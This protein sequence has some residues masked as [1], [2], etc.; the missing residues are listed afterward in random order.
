M[1]AAAALSPTM[2]P[3]SP[4]AFMLSAGLH[5]GVVALLLLLGYATNRTAN[6]DAKVFDVVA[7]EGSAYGEKEAPVFGTPGGVKL[8]A[9]TPPM[10]TPPQPQPREEPKP[11]PAPARPEPVVPKQAPPQAKEQSK[12]APPTERLLPNVTRTVIRAESSAKKQIDKE[13][14]AEAARLSKAEF[15]AKNAAKNPPTSKSNQTKVAKVDTEGIAK[16]VMGGSANSKEG[17]G[18]K[19]LRSD[20]VEVVDAYFAMF[21]QRVSDKFE[22][23]PGLSE[24]L[25]GDFEFTVSPDGTISGGRVVKSSGSREFDNAVLAAI[26]SVRMPP[27]PYSKRQTVGFTFSMADKQRG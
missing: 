20:N 11:E 5:A 7:G 25:E 12:K 1:S 24:S 8:T 2:T 10:V 19:A 13:R 14:K 22:A 4:T 17:A 26:R 23:P 18:G 3:R 6:D 15:D 16:G 9:T 27:H 21:K